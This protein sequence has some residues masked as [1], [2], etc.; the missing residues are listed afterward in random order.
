MR[1]EFEAQ[2]EKQRNE[3]LKADLEAAGQLFCL[4]KIRVVMI[5]TT[6]AS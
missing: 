1:A 6:T 4:D 5:V 3:V 2:R